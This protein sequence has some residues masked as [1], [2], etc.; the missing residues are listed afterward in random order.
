[1][2]RKFL[3]VLV[4]AAFTICNLTAQNNKVKSK[5]KESNKIEQTEEVKQEPA[6]KNSVV[7]KREVIKQEKKQQKSTESNLSKKQSVQKKSSNSKQYK[8]ISTFYEKKV[9]NNIENSDKAKRPR[10]PIYKQT[11]TTKLK[12]S[13]KTPSFDSRNQQIE[14]KK[15]VNSSQQVQKKPR[16]EKKKIHQGSGIHHPHVVIEHQHVTY[17]SPRFY[18]YHI[19]PRYI[20]R[21]IW[22]RQ[23]ID[24]PNGYIFYNGYPYYVYNNY[25]HR[26]SV[27]DS[28][29]FD[30]VDSWNDETY[31]TFYG[32][33]IKDSYD[34]CA[35]L[36]D[37]L[38]AEYGEER[39]FVA[40]R[41]EYDS[42]YKYDWD[43]DDYPDWYWY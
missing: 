24:L 3:I 37:R 15:I 9:T 17:K 30:L 36:R 43:P 20:Y 35:D 16:V 23:Y 40:E 2:D 21:G 14:K 12:S 8:K 38:N 27:E 29:Y 10:T 25:L 18:H 11:T 32:D 26:Y 7:K 42:N 5:L 39:Y 19:P 13:H 22:I 31:A 4:I 34:R 6:V 1:M 28:G 33:T 41:F